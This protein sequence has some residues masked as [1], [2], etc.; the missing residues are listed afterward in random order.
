[1]KIFIQHI[2][3]L[4]FERSLPQNFAVE[5][6][7]AT[8]IQPIVTASFFFWIR[9]RL[10]RSLQTPLFSAREDEHRRGEVFVLHTFIL[11]LAEC[12]P[13][14]LFPSCTLGSDRSPPPGASKLMSVFQLN[15]LGLVT[16]VDL[17]QL[18]QKL[19]RTASPTA[20]SPNDVSHQL[21]KTEGVRI[22]Q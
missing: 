17:P 11:V 1:M 21:L 18:R 3:K 15:L 14:D 10:N 6:E 2:I 4:A 22:L 8:G 7:A 9:W 20:W 16:P 12:E 19:H 5:S 13:L